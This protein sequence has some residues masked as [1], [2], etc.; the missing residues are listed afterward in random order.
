MSRKLPLLVSSA[1]LAAVLVPGAAAQ[2]GFVH[3][4]TP[5]VHPLDM[6]PD[7]AR[8]LA[9]N[10]P[11]NRLE[12]F[13]L[14]SGEPVW[15]GSI[16]VGLDPVSVR[17]RTS[18]EAWV[19]NH[20]SDSV[21]IVDLT[22]GNVVATLATDD[23]PTDVVFARGELHV[24]CVAGPRQRAFVA[25]S[26]A[27]T[28]L[29]F[30]PLDLALPPARIAIR[31]EDPRA[32]AVSP[33]GGEVYVAIHESGNRTTLV[34]GG[35]SGVIGFPPNTVSD[36]A[37]PYAGV[38]PPPNDG[39]AGFEP[40]LAPGLPTPPAVGLIVRQDSSGAWMDDNGEDWT[41]LVS[42]SQAA[43]SGRPVGWTLL[44][45]DVAIVDA[46]TL[47]VRYADGVMNLNMAL[48]VNPASGM[49]T[50]VGTDAINE[51]RFEPNLSGRFIRV[52][53]GQFAPE[54]QSLPAIADL[55]PHLDYQSSTIDPSERSQTL[56]DPRG[57]AWNA[58]GKRG[59][60]SGMGTNNLVVVDPGGARLAGPIEVGEGPTGV[61]FDAAR[62]RVY[63]LNKFE[64]SLSVVDAGSDIEV[65]R[66]PFHDPSPLAVKRGRRHLY[67]AHAT[68]G[69]G[70]VAC[71]SCHI[72]A[73]MDRLAWDLGNPAGE[74]KA[75]GTDQ[76]LGG[77]VPG[78]DVGFEPWH[79]MKG[80]MLTQTLQDIVTHE[81][82][83]WR[84]DRDGI[85]E[86]NGAFEGLLGDDEQLAPGEMQ[87]FEDFLATIAI[88]PNP[89]RN[90]DNSLPTNLP[91]PGHF[92][93][94]RF[95]P[96]GEPLP[97]G[98]AVSGQSIFR[99]PR[100]LD[101]GALSCSAC[102]TRPT[103]GGTDRTLSG[104]QFQ[105][106]PLGPNGENHL[107]L[108]SVDGSTNVTM[109]TPQLRT[110]YERTGLDVTQLESTAGFGYLHDGSIDSIARFVTEPVFNV[111][112]DQET[113]NLVAFLLAF[114]GG[115]A[116]QGSLTNVQEP[117]G[118]PSLGTHA[119]VGK[120]VTLAAA[121]DAAQDAL[122]D[123]M[124]AEAD[125]GD[126]GLVVKGRKD[127]LA[128]GWTYLGADLYQSDRA[129]ETHARAAL[130]ALAAGGSELTWTVVPKGTEK[131]IGIDR[132][133]DGAFDRDEID[134]HSDPAN[135]K[136]R[137]KHVLLPVGR[138]P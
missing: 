62:E 43:L 107:Q 111:N 78:L 3:W 60:V 49:V 72:D 55:N 10:T 118:P 44:D 26:Q 73:R 110:L 54:G 100:R 22:T 56:S 19:V 136:V 64:S 30:D 87:E 132:D 71:A 2:N 105:P 4:E 113:A 52:E 112:S 137:P 63:V 97:N 77:G 93:T 45:H 21:S 5:H 27:N 14:A 90:F 58:D 74:M 106:I 125:Q 17:A 40:P 103:G 135:G 50:V 127:G 68:S 31:G 41:E 108:V 126:V 117:L 79:P 96:A 86:F 120:Q 47:G 84:G 8:L 82:H 6:T 101:G 51:V 85:E 57:I 9:V 109:K 12:V 134:A 130:E 24:Q 18:E 124:T 59:Y 61:A 39:G 88:P 36:P 25:C 99:P 104:G 138:R 70:L 35:A 76:N 80:P 89:F 83:H 102:H 98:N 20:V 16:A 53:L 11:D 128:R 75:L 129:D 13:E 122:L 65:G 116:G 46:S 66:V 91:L 92:K 131:R 95:G 23:E 67:D 42:G 114:S 15:V 1:V 29:V 33:D 34:A 37:G 119:A 121:P 32:M 69:T 38:N 115:T 133:R 28:V 81:P 123:A 48:A 94:G 7:G